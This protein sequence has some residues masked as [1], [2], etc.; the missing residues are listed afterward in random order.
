MADGFRIAAVSTVRD[1]PSCES[2]SVLLSGDFERACATPLAFAFRNGDAVRLPIGGVCVR[3]GGFDGR[4]MVGLSH[5][6]KK[7]S[8]ASDGAELS[9]AGV[10]TTTLFTTTS[11]GFLWLLE[12]VELTIW[13]FHSRFR[14]CCGS[15]LE[16]VL[17]F[18][19]S[20]RS[21]LCLRVLA[22]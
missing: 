9:S 13:R 18:C 1:P 19:C 15:P 21:I 8:P 16:F 2:G 20:S 11:S 17:V 5:E 14:I 10:E 3:D 4:L 7:S 12:M 6:E 22:R